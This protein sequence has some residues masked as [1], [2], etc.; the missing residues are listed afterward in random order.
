MRSGLHDQL[1]KARY[2]DGHV[3]R[4]AQGNLIA[5]HVQRIGARAR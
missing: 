3:R 2:I 5:C 4:A 1:T